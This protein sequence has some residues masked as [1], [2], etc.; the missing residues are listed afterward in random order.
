M[1]RKWLVLFSLGVLFLSSFV[2]ADEWVLQESNAPFHDLHDVHPITEQ[3]VFAVGTPVDHST[4]VIVRTID[5][6]ENWE[7]VREDDDPLYGVC[8]FSRDD[9][10]V[11]G[12]L[13]IDFDLSGP[14]V[15]L[16]HDGGGSWEQHFSSVEDGSLGDVH[17]LE[18]GTAFAVGGLSYVPGTLLIEGTIVKSVDQGE[19]WVQLRSGTEHILEGVFFVNENVG[20]AVGTGGV[21]LKT[22]DGENFEQIAS[23]ERSGIPIGLNDVYC[24]DE[25]RCWVVGVGNIVYVT[26]D[27]GDS[28]DEFETGLYLA[29]QRGIHAVDEEWIWVTGQNSIRHTEDGVTWNPDETEISGP[30]TYL[31]PVGFVRDVQFLPR[32]EDGTLLG[33]AVGDVYNE[34]GTLEGL[35]E[36]FGV[37]FRW[38]EP[39][40]VVCEE[41]ENPCE[42]V[43]AVTYDEDGCVEHYYCVVLPEEQNYTVS[44]PVSCLDGYRDCLEANWPRHA[45]CDETY[46]FC[47]GLDEV[48]AQYQEE[49]EREQLQLFL[50]YL[51]QYDFILEYLQGERVNLYLDGKSAGLYLEEKVSLGDA[52][53]KPSI[54]VSSSQ[55]VLDGIF[56]S[57][58][59]QTEALAALKR[60]DIVVKGKGISRLKVLLLKLSLSFR[61]G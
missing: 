23:F 17:C 59:P 8:S 1:A 21:V 14:T 44:L 37:I 10:L 15:L 42:G 22:T 5:G 52:Y 11:V 43:Y 38:G 58:D 3:L 36:G 51:Q 41:V 50:S 13:D 26:D 32:R 29:S 20:Y 4:G 55:E 60:G 19:S 24:L 28:W 27:G 33:W 47:E 7:V 61:K 2:L 35:Y 18:D 12:F 53:E 40:E 39:R 54:L 46:E 45:D 9:I 56:S 6:G 48:L 34:E 49:Q 25:D 30:P 57:K 31:I 16:S